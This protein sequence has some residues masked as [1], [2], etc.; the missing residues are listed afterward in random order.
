MDPQYRSPINR[1]VAPARAGEFAALH[2][3]PLRVWP[4]VVLAPMAGVT[5]PPFRSLCK[6]FGAGLYVSEMITARA[7]VEGNRKTLLLSEFAPDETVRSLQLY[8]VDPRY[9]AEAVRFLVGEGRVDH[10]D[11]NFGCPVRKVTSKGG[12]AAIPLKPRLLAGIVRAQDKWPSKPV[13]VV[14]AFTAGGTTDLLARA[15]TQKLS[16]K[17]G[18]SFI[19]DNKPG[20]GGNIGTEFV[21][22]SPADGYTLIVNSVGPISVNQSLYKNMG[23]DPL[24]DLVP[25]VQIADVPNVLVVN[26]AVPVKTFEEFIAYA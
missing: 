4:P 8:G 22:R 7:L 9:V 20:G 21:V 26:P 1:D 17:L 18:Q 16:E 2:V 24:V 15:V 5:N 14:V 6:R 25:I 10:L 12:G 19:I 11:M 3:G 13:K 23:Y